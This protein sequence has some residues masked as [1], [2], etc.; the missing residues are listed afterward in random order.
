LSEGRGYRSLHLIGSPVQVKYPPGFPV[1]LSLLWRFGGSLEAVQHLVGLLHPV[2]IAAAAGLLW[3]VGRAHLAA[4][5]PALGLLVVLPFLLEASIDYYTIVLSE[6]WFILG[7]AGVIALWAGAETLEP[8]RPRLWRLAACS[9]LVAVTILI[10]TQAIVLLPAMAVG[11]AARR[12]RA[13]ERIVAAVLIVAPLALWRLYHSALIA[14]GPISH[15]PD[16]GPYV[17]WLRGSG[18]SLVPALMAVVQ[19]NVVLYLSEFGDYL[20]GIPVLGQASVA[21]LLGGSMV[22]AGCAVRRHPLLALS[23]LGGLGLIL[24]WPFAQDRLLLP[25]LPFLGL[26]TCAV[27]PRLVASA[28]RAAHR[29]FALGVALM[30]GLVLLHQV[31]VR[32][33]GV[34]A[35]AENREPPYYTPSWMLPLNSRYI[36]LAS[37][38][39]REN[40]QPTDRLMIDNHSGIYLYS[41]RTTVPANPSE[42]RFQKS[43]YAVPGQYLATRILQD[44]LDYVIIGLRNPGIM[45]DLDTVS[46]RC[47]GVLSWG[48]TNPDDSKYIFRVR[49]NEPCLRT[50]LSAAE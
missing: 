6:P 37:R 7:W 3:W 44:S 45:R 31:D 20:S 41:G 13:T 26:A 42:S 8:G 35:F 34:A 47:P 43:V 16:E 2:V 17:E 18:A 23:A 32:K 49:R 11:L 12:Y 39:V 38:W 29:G 5:R 19:N 33:A 4:P 24:V 50:L 28:P 30:M 40:T 22:G 10:R 21:I 14:H 1:I 27:V 9:G 15:L 48:G 25:L 46:S 36:V